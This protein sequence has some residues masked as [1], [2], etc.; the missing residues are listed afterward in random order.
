MKKM[1]KILCLVLCAVMLAGCLQIG[2]LNIQVASEAEEA[3]ADASAQEDD[4][5]ENG[6]GEPEDGGAAGGLLG[7]AVPE[8][9]PV[10]GP[11]HQ[12]N[13]VAVKDADP[14]MAVRVIAPSGYST[15][16]VL[17]GMTLK[18][19][20]HPVLTDPAHTDLVD[21]DYLTAENGGGIFAVYCAGG[22]NPGDS[23][24]I[25]LTDGNLCY[26]GQNPAVRLYNITAASADFN[27]MKLDGD[28]QFLNAAELAPAEAG[29]A[30]K[31]DGM[32]RYDMASGALSGAQG[33][34]SFVYRE[35]AYVVGDIVAIYNG[36]RPDERAVTDTGS[37][38]A[39]T[40]ITEIIPRGDGT[41]QYQYTGA[42]QKDV[43]FIPDVI[44]VHQECLLAEG[45]DSSVTLDSS[46]LTF[47]SDG[48]FR[49]MNLDENTE[50]EPGDYLA[51][52]TGTPEDGEVTAYAEILEV[53]HMEDEDGE[54]SAE[55]KYKV[56]SMQEMMTSIDAH[57]YTTLS[58]AQIRSSYNE[59][60]VEAQVLESLT[61][62]GYLME[63][64]YHLAETALN[65]EEAQEMFGDTPL[66]QL[67]FYYGENEEHSM[68]GSDYL[69]MANG[70]GVNAVDIKG[71][72]DVMISPNIVHFAGKTGY[73]MGVRVEVYAKYTITI[74]GSDAMKAALKIEITF[75]FENEVVMGYTADS[76]SIWK[77]KWIF[78]YIYDYSISGSVSDGIYIGAGFTAVASTI[79]N[80]K[81][82]VAAGVKWPEDVDHT[83]GAEKVMALAN[84]VKGLKD[85]HD[86]I[87][88]PQ[89]TGG[90]SL[91]EKYS[92]FIKSSNSSWVDLFSPNIF[93]WNGCID[94]LHIIAFRLKADFVVSAQLYAA[95]GA[96]AN[97][98]RAYRQVFNFMLIHET[99]EG[100]Q[101]EETDISR[102]RADVYIFG[103]LGLRIGIRLT[104]SVGLF[105]A[106]L[107]SI[108]LELE[109]GM[110]ARFWGFFYAGVEINDMGRSNQ[111]TDMY[112][113][114]G[115]LSELGVYYVVTFFAQLGDGAIAYRRVLASDG[116]PTYSVGVT[117]IINDFAYKQDDESRNFTALYTKDIDA[118]EI[119]ENIFEM[120]VMSIKTGTVSTESK[121]KQSANDLYELTLD[122]PDFAYAYRNGKH[123][124]VRK[125]NENGGEGTIHMTLK[126]KGRSFEQLSK[127]LERTI[128]IQ[129]EANQVHMA[130][131]DFDGKVFYEIVEAKGEPLSEDLWPEEEP[132]KRG[133]EFLGWLTPEGDPLEELPEVMPD[134]DIEYT[135][136]WYRYYV[137]V[138]VEY[139]MP[140]DTSGFRRQ[141]L[142][143][144]TDI[145]SELFY[146]GD[147]V[148]NALDIL[149]ENHLL[150]T[151]E[152][153]QIEGKDYYQHYRVYVRDSVLCTDSVA[154]DGTTTF[155]IC[156]EWNSSTITF[157]YGDGRKSEAQVMPGNAIEFPEVTRQ[158]FIFAGW[159]DAEGNIVTETVYCDGDATFTAV[160]E[161]IPPTLTVEEQIKIKSWGIN[162]Y[163]KT[164][165]TQELVF[166]SYETTVQALI[167]RVGIPAGYVY[168][169]DYTGRQLS[170][171]ITI[172][173]DGTTK[174]ILRFTEDNG[175]GSH[176]SG[177]SEDETTPEESSTPEEE[178]EPEET[179]PEETE[180]EETVPEE[181]EPE[182]TE[183]GDGLDPWE[184][185][186]DD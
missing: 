29:Q 174:V 123:L 177:D 100:V 94:P 43:L 146:P 7:G 79:K 180:P 110:Y 154:W 40:R 168:S 106:R 130:F 58:E 122:D 103:A 109:G 47:T 45:S 18:N 112:Y 74:R 166:D 44:P 48:E 133:Y 118:V 12:E 4:M 138:R 63:S 167:D 70:A 107:D 82:E 175:G 73:G 77:W 66:D 35:N 157:D 161:K 83:A 93:D 155:K 115:I 14:G 24:Q 71:K 97:Y 16:Q 105:D 15:A 128:E 21:P 10:V 39:Y 181:T 98:E 183:P 147:P 68:K 85:K 101:T 137:D 152:D 88:P 26:E 52:Y 51:F 42:D 102:F 8:G 53:R 55:L 30:L 50:V 5:E 176:G 111:K 156:L 22:F 62:N 57:R 75:F 34:G 38:V 65:T 20:S 145:I 140:W 119:P 84:Y 72:P 134:E 186:E 25:Q 117:S 17:A 120:T 1:K 184:G 46:A 37:E 141:Y 80:Q 139:Y 114:G 124:L 158:G 151:E 148:E 126:W 81:E 95:I 149:L 89:D 131:L 121:A 99:C 170:D 41:A 31:L 173:E 27:R 136:D 11:D 69:A 36:T 54:D 33:S 64:S 135:S 96:G 19:L 159:M 179:E 132:E 6:E 143:D 59:A 56:V 129:W 185:E 169:Y 182:E 171:V 163:W 153:H 90:G 9:E 108:G 165:T 78:P 127:D 144:D 164:V 113:S 116:F 76:T 32:F 23:Y 150:R 28:V 160:W 142:L 3:G 172:A 61:N 2:D 91:S 104:V 178:T 67:T 86:A 92:A 162:Y 60:A 49:E 87:F 125:N 13:F